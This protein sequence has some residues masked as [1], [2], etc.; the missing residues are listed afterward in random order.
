MKRQ[1]KPGRQKPGLTVTAVLNGERF[2][3]P[4]SYLYKRIIAPE[5]RFK[6]RPRAMRDCMIEWICREILKRP[7]NVI[8]KNGPGN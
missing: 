6:S 4:Q 1:K 8:P 3:I 2:T 7:G 5:H